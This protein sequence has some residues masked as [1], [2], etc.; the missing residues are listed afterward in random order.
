MNSIRNKIPKFPYRLLKKM[1]ICS[2]HEGYAGDIK[3][4]FDEIL[5]RKGKMTAVLWIWYHAIVAIPGAFK[6]YFIWRGCMFKNYM[7][8]S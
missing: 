3:E 5:S 8:I 1:W 2:N 6:S 7:K 4:E